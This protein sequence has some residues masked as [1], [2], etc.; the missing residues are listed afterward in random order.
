MQEQQRQME[1]ML[2]KALSG[3]SLKMVGFRDE[4]TQRD[5]SFNCNNYYELASPA[6]SISEVAAQ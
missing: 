1:N 2:M 3:S 4:K 5:I 6:P